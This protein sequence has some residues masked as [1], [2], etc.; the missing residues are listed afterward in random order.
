M[1]NIKQLFYA[2]VLT[3]VISSVTFAGE[4]WTPGIINPPPPSGG[5]VASST[6]K[7]E[8]TAL[9]TLTETTLLLFKR[10]LSLF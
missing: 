7:A 5:R 3:L 10:L 2:A 8:E 6:L 9:D 1:K 4:M